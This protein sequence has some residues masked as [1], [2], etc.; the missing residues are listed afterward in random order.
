M[1]YS[2]KGTIAKI[3]NKFLVIEN[4]G[5]GYEVFVSKPSSYQEGSDV[6]LLIYHHI[7]EDAEF[8]V[9]FEDLREKEAFKLL[10]HVNG[11]G[12]K[13]ALT[14]LGSMEINQLL[15]AISEN[16]ISL[17]ESISGVSNKIASQIVLDLKC[18]I[19]KFNVE[20]NIYYF[21][22][23]EALKKLQFKVKEIDSVLPY[24]YTKNG[25]KE[26][27]LKEALRRL[28]NVHKR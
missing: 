6:K 21:E 7:K 13:G 2:I 9:G 4:N 22:V 10:L 28:N 20:N 5:I 26:E 3:E 27:M 8:L 18:Y 15:L 19:S 12:P 23:R 14:I 24:V 17:I 11:I 25:T 16:D 1:F